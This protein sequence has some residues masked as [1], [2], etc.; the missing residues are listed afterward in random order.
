MNN[1][2]LLLIH[3]IV[4]SGINYA[5]SHMG[6]YILDHTPEL[7]N[8]S[9][10]LKSNDHYL[11]GTCKKV[12]IIIKLPQE[13]NVTSIEFQNNEWLSNFIHRFELLAANNNKFVQLGQFEA[14]RTRNKQ[15]FLIN[16]NFFTSTIK[17][18]INSYYGRHDFFTLTHFKVY[19]STILEKIMASKNSQLIVK[20]DFVDENTTSNLEIYTEDF[21]KKNQMFGY[22]LVGIFCYMILCMLIRHI[23]DGMKIKKKPKTD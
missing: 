19:G 1:L 9:S 6:T 22:V 2:I 23:I 7:R 10:I 16:M 4:S 12:F 17:I 13:L 5:S 8:V 3:Q 14:K 11:I 18:E 15:V 20:Q 21:K